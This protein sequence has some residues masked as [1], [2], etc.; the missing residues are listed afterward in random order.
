[1]NVTVSQR[2][3]NI[4]FSNLIQHTVT[5]KITSSLPRQHKI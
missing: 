5:Q 3:I 2:K 4:L 1:M